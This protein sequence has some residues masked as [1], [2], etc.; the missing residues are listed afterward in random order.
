MVL[1]DSWNSLGNV[2]D[3]SITD[4]FSSDEDMQFSPLPS[5]TPP[6]ACTTPEAPS[7]SPVSPVQSIPTPQSPDMMSLCSDSSVESTFANQSLSLEVGQSLCLG[8]GQVGPD[9]ESSVEVGVG[10]GGE[11]LSDVVEEVQQT[12]H[13]WFGF[14]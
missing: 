7:F 4:M 3:T 1:C 8:S 13:G 6:L 5:N 9:H 2:V 14:R 12:H 10:Q 11:V